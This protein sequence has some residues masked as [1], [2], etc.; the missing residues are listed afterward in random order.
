VNQDKSARYHTLKRR[1]ALVSVA[2][3]AAFLVF[4]AASKAS[5]WLASLAA[6][7]V[8]HLPLPT[9]TIPTV[10]VL[11]Y[12]ALFG[13]LHEAG[14]LPIAFYRGFLI[15]H[16]Y[17]LS[18]ESLR[19][20]ATDQAKAGLLGF[21]LSLVGFALLYMAIRRWPEDWWL[22]AACGFTLFVVVMARLAPVLV[23]PLFFTLK[24]LARD[25]LR[26]RLVALAARAG[27]PVTDA[28]EWQLSDRTKKGNAALTGLG[29]TRRILV[30]DTLLA[31][32]SDEEIEVVLAH[33]IGHHAHHDIW[34]GLVLEAGIAVLGFFLASRALV[35][36][37]PRLGWQGVADVA[38]VPSLLLTAGVLSLV[39]VP[40]VNAWSRGMERAADTFAWE[41][42]GNAAAFAS[43]MQRLGVQ[44]LAEERPS[45]LV[46][47]LF[48]T[49]PPFAERI[50]AARE[51][52]EKSR[53]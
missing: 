7:L 41:V 22:P 8:A 27:V 40:A 4:F 39:L 23:L 9:A 1:A 38:G 44:N 28:F 13:T 20:W 51:W 12:V 42:T 18:T 17:G 25:D 15:E 3:S 16:R 50:A 21:V 5:S 37:A 19:A 26:Q 46:R 34:K 33:E 30:S 45:R 31:S 10:I 35:A 2:W 48:Y 53:A 6:G 11:V 29:R 24:P 43:A 32:H 49:H 47:W 14:S 52:E 36:L